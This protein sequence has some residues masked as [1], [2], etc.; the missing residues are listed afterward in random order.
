M[1][2]DS[3]PKFASQRVFFFSRRYDFYWPWRNLSNKRSWICTH[4]GDNMLLLSKRAF[5]KKSKQKCK[6]DIGASEKTT[7][8][9]FI[10][11]KNLLLC[12][13]PHQNEEALKQRMFWMQMEN[14]LLENCFNVPVVESY[15]LRC[16]IKYCLMI[17]IMILYVHKIVIKSVIRSDST[18]CF[19]LRKDANPTVN[20]RNLLF[21][22]AKRLVAVYF[23]DSKRN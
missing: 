14:R 16:G 11:F 5:Q 20:F 9:L 10:R 8:T 3:F 2:K 18:H 12:F 1:V 17:F 13:H 7:K 6:E 19:V 22:T 4:L 15:I 21:Q 23:I